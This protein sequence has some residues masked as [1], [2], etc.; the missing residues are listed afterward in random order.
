MRRRL[1][2]WIKISPPTSFSEEVY[3]RALFL[4]LLLLALDYYS[5]VL[6]VAAVS[7]LSER[8]RRASLFKAKCRFGYSSVVRLSLALPTDQPTGQRANISGDGTQF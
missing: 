5:I 1:N 8:R 4:L 6:Q 2:W 7:P 3:T